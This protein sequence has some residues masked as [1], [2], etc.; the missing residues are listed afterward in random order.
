[1]GWKVPEPKSPLPGTCK[2][3]QDTVAPTSCQILG[4]R[5]MGPF[6]LDVEIPYSCQLFDAL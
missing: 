3:M 2:L 1:M 6:R 5:L 4:F